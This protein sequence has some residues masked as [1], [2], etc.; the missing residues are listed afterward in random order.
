M[1]G[2]YYLVGC[3]FE[4]CKHFLEKRPFFRAHTAGLG[5]C[6]LGR[7]GLIG[8]NRSAFMIN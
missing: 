6:R 2:F 8:V 1:C 5:K 3:I 4:K 7:Y